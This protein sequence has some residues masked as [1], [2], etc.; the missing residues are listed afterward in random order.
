MDEVI[1]NRMAEDLKGKELGGWRIG[2][3]LGVGKS[4]IVFR[5]TRG[6]ESGAVKVFDR[7]L[8]KRYGAKAQSERGNREKALVGKHHPNLIQ[9]LDAGYD[10]DKDLF[11]VVMEL[12]PGKNL[13]EVSTAIPSGREHPLFVQV[14]EAA[15]FLE[16]L[17]LA[18][19]DIKPENIGITDDFSRAVLLDLGV[20]RPVEGLSSLT[21][22]GAQKQFVGTL[23][24]SPPEMLYRVEEQSREGW[25]AITFYQLGAVLYDLLARRPL[26]AEH[27]YPFAK[28]V[29]AV[30]E[31]VVVNIEAPTS[32]PELRLL[33]QDCLTKDARMRLRLVTWER[34]LKPLPPKNDLAAIRDRLE[35]RRRSAAVV[36]TA[37]VAASARDAQRALA[38]TVEAVLRSASHD[39]NTPSFVIDKD[40]GPSDFRLRVEY[41]ASTRHAVGARFAIYV[42]CSVADV[43]ARV[44]SVRC[45]A[46]IAE[47]ALPQQA[48][49]TWLVTLFEGVEDQD[50]LR[51][52]IEALVLVTY[53]GAAEACAT[54]RVTSLP[55]DLKPAEGGL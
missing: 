28:L 15:Q 29:R 45:A 17:G 47:E 39:A 1:A 40:D 21:D 13:A 32:P 34:V 41:I 36:V 16:T 5:S 14:A 23:Q 2:E 35:M 38:R 48:D 22:H 4:A 49:P 54:S 33:A 31:E 6:S 46:A 11:F 43:A 42:V 3:R 27:V 20:L 25:R 52:R 10:D 19:R 30:T 55:I 8:V 51:T 12:F 44:V 53:D 26:F 7:E 50:V 9:I 18:H 24:Y 37:P